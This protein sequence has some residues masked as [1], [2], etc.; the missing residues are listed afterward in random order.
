[1]FGKRMKLQICA[2]DANN[3]GKCLNEAQN[4]LKVSQQFTEFPRSELS[5]MQISEMRYKFQANKKNNNERVITEILI[6]I[7]RN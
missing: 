5:L 3:V 2:N 4:H 6:G 1:M 7:R